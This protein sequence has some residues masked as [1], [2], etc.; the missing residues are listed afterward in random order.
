MS[1]YLTALQTAFTAEDIAAMRFLEQACC[2]EEQVH[3]N[4][5]I[6]YLE[7]GSGDPSI[8]CYHHDQL[9]GMLTWYGLG[10]G[11][12]VVN[13]M[14]H[15]AYRRQGLFR[16]MLALARTEQH[17]VGI[18]GLEYRVAAACPSGMAF[19]SRLGGQRGKVEYS[20]ILA[21]T[22]QAEPGHPSLTLRPMA[23]SDYE[24]AV[25]CSMQA[26]GDAEQWTRDYLTRT[27]RPPRSA[28]IVS[29]EGDDIGFLRFFHFHAGAALIQD[30]CVLPQRQKS[31]YGYALVC[32]AV[33]L[34]HAQGV[35]QIRLN[36]DADN[37]RA[38]GL[39]R[40]AGF[41][42]EAEYHHYAVQG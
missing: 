19:V 8:L 42:V 38:L 21:N 34:L 7:S 23:E 33:R 28:W 11:K 27:A 30:V 37:E 2:Q 36:V 6:D 24:F 4:M 18:D 41:A 20:M 32:E 15:P 16:R 1:E 13:G 9:A 14:V 10:D 40:K 31:G 5:G 26:F 29:A 3:L 12:A 22:P 39:Y 25:A 17:K 35:E